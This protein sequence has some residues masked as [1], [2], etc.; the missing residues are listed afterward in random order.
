MVKILIM[1]AQEEGKLKRFIQED[2]LD[3]ISEFLNWGL[4]MGGEGE[5]SI[6]ITVGL[7]LLLITAFI[8]TNFV[9]KTIRR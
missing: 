6:H 4:H 9:L 3:S 2:L 8:A 7:L 5:N 1:L